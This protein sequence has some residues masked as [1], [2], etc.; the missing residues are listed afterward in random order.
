M[1]FERERF[2]KLMAAKKVE[3]GQPSRP[4]LEIL[5]QA[6]VGAANLTGDANWDI[7]LSYIQAAVERTEA[8]IRMTET[9]LSS[10]DVVETTDLMRLKIQL[11]R[12]RSQVSAWNAVI[13]L[14]KDIKV[15]G[16]KAKEVLERLAEVE[17]E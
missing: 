15:E 12:L 7:F 17:N 9:L 8:D 13:S 4:V 11:A 16:E 3:R 5:A 10:P 2:E 6:E 14:P 1:T